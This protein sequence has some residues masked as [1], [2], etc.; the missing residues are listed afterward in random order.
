MVMLKKSLLGQTDIL[1][2]QLGLGTVKFGRNTGVKY[3]QNFT[4]P[5]D[6]EIIN[7]LSLAKDLN[8][9][10]LDTAPAYGN[11]EERLGKILQGQRHDWVIVD[12][13]GEEFTN[14]QSVYNFKPD[15]I[16]KIVKQSLI[17]L[18]TDYIDILLIHSDGND[19]EIIEEY[20]VFTTLEKLKTAGHI[21]AFGMSS[22][23]VA[24]G[25]ATIEHT[26][27]AMVT[28]NPAYQDE[29]SVLDKAQELN[30]GILIKKALASGHL[31]KL[32]TTADPV[33]SSIDFIFAH[34]GVSSVIIGTINPEHL[35]DGAKHVLQASGS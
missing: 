28:Y 22:K 26:D 25:L 1:I 17:K 35:K 13:V 19:Q 33:Q 24:G 23:T 27:L 16:N 30:K 3:P 4:I 14:N 18:N 10:L 34:P 15:Y 11:S 9:N 5:N 29:K 6:Q 2:S 32:A 8:I 7:L 12:K 31:D 21:R 20:E